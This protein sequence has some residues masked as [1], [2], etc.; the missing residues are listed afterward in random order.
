M[1]AR[2]REMRCALCLEK[3]FEALV[4]DSTK[5]RR[6]DAVGEVKKKWAL[7][8]EE[9]FGDRLSYDSDLSQMV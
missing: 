6:L 4:C 5:G 2:W 1:L 7:G 9:S 8:E 3:I